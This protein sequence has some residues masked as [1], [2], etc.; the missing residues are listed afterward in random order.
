MD[1]VEIVVL[2][3]VYLLEFAEGNGVGVE[4]LFGQVLWLLYV[5][6][7]VTGDSAQ[8]VRVYVGA[9]WEYFFDDDAAGLRIEDKRCLEI[10]L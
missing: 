6:C 3:R 9:F 1:G 4:V 10:E 7:L 5:D 8:L 2:P